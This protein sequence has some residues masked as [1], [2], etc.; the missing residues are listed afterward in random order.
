MASQTLILSAL[1]LERTIRPS[2]SS[3]ASR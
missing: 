3:L 1:S 2:E